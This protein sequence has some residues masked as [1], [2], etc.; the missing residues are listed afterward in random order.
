[1]QV[2]YVPVLKSPPKLRSVNCK[3]QTKICIAKYLHYRIVP[4]QVTPLKYNNISVH[5]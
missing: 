5:L 1:M 2:I 3:S 4:K